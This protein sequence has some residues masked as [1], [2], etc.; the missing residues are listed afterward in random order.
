M[1]TVN[2]EGLNYAPALT[3][4]E[5]EIFFTRAGPSGPRLFKAARP[6]A[7]QPFGPPVPITAITEIVEAPALSPDGGALYFHKKENGRFVLYRIT[8]SPPAPRF[9]TAS[10]HSL[11][12]RTSYGRFF[13]EVRQ[14]GKNLGAGAP[15]I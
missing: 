9:S 4:S 12:N 3:A 10:K 6:T 13:G 2:A 7:T 14:P 5:L 15:G 1:Q 8:R 11:D